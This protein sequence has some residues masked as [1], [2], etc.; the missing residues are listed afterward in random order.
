MHLVA[1]LTAGHKL[2][3]MLGHVT[4]VEL[5]HEIISMVILLLPLIQEGQLFRIL[6]NWV[7][8]YFLNSCSLDLSKYMCHFQIALDQS[9]CTT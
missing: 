7:R 4:F 1:Q 2:E 8:K 5:D 3:F 9:N 6:E